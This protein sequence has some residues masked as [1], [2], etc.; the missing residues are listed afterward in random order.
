MVTTFPQEMV[1]ILCHDFT[2]D[3]KG[4][5]MD[6]QADLRDKEKKNINRFEEAEVK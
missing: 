5:Y 4:L 2:G 3:E 1:Q 6:S